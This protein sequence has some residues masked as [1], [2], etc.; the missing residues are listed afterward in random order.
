MHIFMQRVVRYVINLK[1]LGTDFP[2]APQT[3]KIILTQPFRT[4]NNT[5]QQTQIR[6]RRRRPRGGSII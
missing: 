1:T 5:I 2:S 4:P 6:L 3:T